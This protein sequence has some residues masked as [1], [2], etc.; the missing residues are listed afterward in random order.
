MVGYSRLTAL[1]E[2]G[3][4]AHWQALQSDMIGRLVEEH[5]GRVFQQKG[6]EVLMDFE[7]ASACVACAF[8][9]QEETVE[10]ASRMPSDR[11]IL[12]RIGVDLGQVLPIEDSGLYGNAL[13]I[14]ARLQ[15]I[16]DPGGVVVSLAV[17]AELDDELKERFEDLG[18]IPLKNIPDPVRAYRWKHSALPVEQVSFRIP[19]RPPTDCPSVAVLPFV[20]VGIED[21]GDFLADGLVEDIVTSLATLRELFVISRASTL[22]YRSREVDALQ[23]GRAL[24]V[25]Y[26]VTGSVAKSNDRLRIAAALREVDTGADLWAEHMDAKLEGIFEVLDDV[27][28]RIVSRVAPHIQQAELERSF[29]RRP[30][31]LTAYDYTIRALNLILRLDREDFARAKPLLD[32]AIET[33]PSFAMP[34]A[35]AA[36]WH[37]LRVGQGWSMDVAVDTSEAVRLAA[38][39]IELDRHNSLALAHFG[40]M[41]SFLFHEHDSGLVYLDRAIEACPNNPVAWGLSSASKSYVGD[42]EEAIRRAE[43]ALRL[44]PFDPALFLPYMILMVAHYTHGN[45]EEAV[46]WGRVAMSENDSFTAISRY[47]AAALAASGAI[48]EAKVM[49]KVLLEREPRFSLDRYQALRLPFRDRQQRE[50]HLEHLRLAGLPE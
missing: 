30:E 10:Y 49:G 50:R 37:S 33:E 18:A 5:G 24:G 39:A 9:I 42:G 36:R 22:A 29:R 20:N 13:N 44:S 40:H 12:F 43:H 19:L 15:T 21:V 38:R 25:R 3:T 47:L 41:K 35:W 28:A 14:A 16:A 7:S 1:D 8:A 23:V 32:K 31:S 46:K 48:A 26:I 6:D 11:R 17:F 2:P 34:Y 27:V 45:Y 4:L